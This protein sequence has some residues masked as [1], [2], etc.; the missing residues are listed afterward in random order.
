MIRVGP[1]LR[2]GPLVLVAAFCLAIAG[3]DGRGALAIFGDQASNSGNTLG[4]FH[5]IG[6]E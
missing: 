2:Y 3:L 1:L 6:W 4:Q 5:L